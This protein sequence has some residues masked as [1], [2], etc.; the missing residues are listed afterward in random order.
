MKK[1]LKQIL[2]YQKAHR[3]EDGIFGINACK[4]TIQANL[5]Y[6]TIPKDK[7]LYEMLCHYVYQSNINIFFNNTM[8]LACWELIQEIE[9][10]EQ[11]Q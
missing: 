10:N 3:Q 5:Q 11:E 7:A 8:V 1:T 6:K 9:Y 4:S 2:E